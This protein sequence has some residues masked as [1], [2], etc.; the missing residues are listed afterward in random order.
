MSDHPLRELQKILLAEPEVRKRTHSPKKAA[1]HLRR[2]GF[3]TALGNGAPEPPLTW[4]RVPI[5]ASPVH[6]SAWIGLDHDTLLKTL[7]LG[8]LPPRI[9]RPTVAQAWEYARGRCRSAMLH[10]ERYRYY[11][12][13]RT[14]EENLELRDPVEGE[15]LIPLRQLCETPDQ[16][17]LLIIC[18]RAKVALLDHLGNPV[19]N[20]NHSRR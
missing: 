14:S 15:L 6:G 7:A 8:S 2:R 20:P 4:T 12:E 19:P 1:A 5:Q 18:R 9:R 13:A 11:Q 10:G 3:Q 16:P 17:G